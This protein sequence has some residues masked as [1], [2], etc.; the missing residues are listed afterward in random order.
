[1]RLRVRRLRVRLRLRRGRALKPERALLAAQAARLAPFRER[2]LRRVHPALRGATLDLGCGAGALTAELATRVRGPV[3][4]VDRDADALRSVPAPAHRVRADA[5]ALT[6]G[7]A[8]F[9]LV[10]TQAAWLWFGDP[11]A[12]AREVRRVLAPGGALV[13]VGEP[14]FGG[15]L[16]HPPE[17]A[18]APAWISALRRAGADP[19]VG[20]KLPGALAAAGFASAEAEIFGRLEPPTGV[21][22]LRQAEAALLRGL[23]LTPGEERAVTKALGA[24]ARAGGDALAFVPLLGVVAHA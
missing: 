21:P 1:M 5:H 13:A 14:D 19:F 2:L 10:V 17:T 9:D 3:I 11:A 22:A 24:A 15:A 6:F 23:G 8:S 20:R 16:E 18:L 4:A 12:V 7:D